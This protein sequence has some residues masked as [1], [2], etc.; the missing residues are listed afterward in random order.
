MACCNSALKKTCYNMAPS[1][2]FIHLSSFA[3]H[4]GEWELEEGYSPKL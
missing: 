3:I 1:I 4:F 2:Y